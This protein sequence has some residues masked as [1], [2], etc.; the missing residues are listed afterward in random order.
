[1]ER[2]DESALQEALNEALPYIGNMV[3]KT[4][5]VKLGGSALG[6]Y[7]TTLEDVVTLSHLNITSVLVHG[8][9][10]AISGWLKRIGKQPVFVNG[11]RVT[12]EETM[13]VATMVL[14]GKVNKDLVCDLARHGGKAAGVSGL[15]GGILRARQKN[16][17]L[18]LVGEITSVD[19]SLVKTLVGA[20][21]IPVVAPIAVGE[22]GQPLN[23]N[24]DTAAAEV[25]VAL[26]AEKLIFLT[27]VPGILGP[28]GELVTEL[29]ADRA[30][31]FINWGVISGGMVPKA[32]AC[33]RALGAVK[34][35]HIVD[36]RAP[37][38]LL[39]ELLTRSGVGTMIIK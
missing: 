9:G 7:D 20:G 8:G 6:S 35:S 5:V 4:I 23:V 32:E 24:A 1:M 33:L 27:D 21:Y 13:E 38:A 16:E 39:R 37:H 12:D 18:G 34:R 25:A 17:Q 22:D 31:E 10:N 3:G 26:R 29:S 14:A 11:L 28:E 19:L 15:D 30:R 2:R 36:G